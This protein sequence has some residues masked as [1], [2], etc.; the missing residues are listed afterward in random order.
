MFVLKII[1][2]IILVLFVVGLIVM[3]V[4]ARLSHNPNR[5]AVYGVT[6]SKSFAEHLQ[7]D[8][9]KVY[10]EMLDDLEVKYIRIPTYWD[11]VE[12]E[13]GKYNWDDI[14]WQIDEAEKREARVVLVVGRRQPRWPEC[15]DP[16]W[17]EKL[18]HEQARAKILKNIE[19]VVKRYKDRDVIE[20]WQVENE[21]FLDFF[22]ECPK[23]KRKELQEEINQV[24]ALDKRKILLTDSGELS[25]WYPLIKMGDLFGTTL[26]RT[27]YNKYIGYWK[28]FFV[29]PGFYRA[30]AYFWGKPQDATYVAELQ[31]EP[32]F[33]DG[34][35]NTPVSEHYKTMN[36]QQLIENAEYANDTGFAR[37]YFWGIEW[38]FWL[39]TIQGDDSVWEAAKTYF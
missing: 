38:W 31:A 1:L 18:S 37:A 32:W 17:V 33:T 15:H 2:L 35:L 13:Q 26:Y 29:P 10:T 21:A 4:L 9:K 14:D 34:P 19:L 12:P 8:W 36:A 11:N 27:T 30:K 6:F 28:Y 3:F 5:Q 22:G 20:M 16:A 7:L 39:K 24:K 25:T 23:I